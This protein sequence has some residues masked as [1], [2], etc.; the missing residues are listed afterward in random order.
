MR[1]NS[2]EQPSN[3]DEMSVAEKLAEINAMMKDIRSQNKVISCDLFKRLDPSQIKVIV[4]RHHEVK[5][6]IDPHT[7]YEFEILIYKTLKY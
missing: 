1:K 4:V 5:K 6:S 3:L 2:A 7:E